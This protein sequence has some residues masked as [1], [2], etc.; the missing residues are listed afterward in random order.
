MY[1]QTEMEVEVVRRKTEYN[2][3]VDILREQSIFHC[4]S[5]NQLHDVAGSMTIHCIQAGNNFEGDLEN[6]Y[7]LVEDGEIELVSLVS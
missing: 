3:I 1:I 5:L 2:A 6:C 4:L 7:Y